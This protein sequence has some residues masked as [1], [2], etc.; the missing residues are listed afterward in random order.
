VLY[1]LTSKVAISRAES[2]LTNIQKELVERNAVITQTARNGHNSVT[3]ANF[4]Y[5]VSFAPVLSSSLYV[6]DF[7]GTEAQRYEAENLHLF[8]LQDIPHHIQY[9]YPLDNIKDAMKNSFFHTK[10]FKDHGRIYHWITVMRSD[11]R[12]YLTYQGEPMVEMDVVACFPWLV[13]NLVNYDIDHTQVY[14]QLQQMFLDI[15]GEPITRSEAKQKFQQLVNSKKSNPLLKAVAPCLQD[16]EVGRFIQEIQK[17]GKN[18]SERFRMLGQ[19]EGRFIERV[20]ELL[21]QHRIVF[22]T[23]HDCVGVP[24]GMIH[25]AKQAFE[26]AAEELFDKNN[27]IMLR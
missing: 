5:T 7:S 17:I 14:E 22:Y 6:S 21:M 18:G 24:N 4:Y 12:T 15:K 1:E 25:L 13:K 2:L 3:D 16:Y 9:L 27:G 20:R 8:V 23:V 26:E 10:H 11:C 19:L